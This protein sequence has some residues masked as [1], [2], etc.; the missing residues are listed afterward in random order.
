MAVLLQAEEIKRAGVVAG[1]RA[2]LQGTLPHAPPSAI[3]DR[4]SQEDALVLCFLGCPPQASATLSIPTHCKDLFMK[5]GID[6]NGP[7]THHGSTLSVPNTLLPCQLSDEEAA[8]LPVPGT[9]LAA[10]INSYLEIVQVW[11]R[12]IREQYPNYSFCLEC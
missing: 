4:T 6:W 8:I 2:A 5:T 3:P 12:I 1:V 11:L 10:A 9:Y 7:H